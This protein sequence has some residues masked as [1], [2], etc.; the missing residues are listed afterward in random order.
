MAD[1]FILRDEKTRGPYSMDQIK[2]LA[3]DGKL[4]TTDKIKKDEGSWQLITQV[5]GLQINPSSA[6]EI[7]KK[8]PQIP[9]S[10]IQSGRAAI[11]AP[12]KGGGI[13]ILTITA[14]L[15][16]LAGAIGGLGYFVY[17]K[18]GLSGFVG[19]MGGTNPY[20]NFSQ[21]YADNR[22]S[23][24]NTLVA[25]DK[26]KAD[27][28]GKALDELEK[29]FK[30]NSKIKALPIDGSTHLKSFTALG[31][32]K[33]GK[34]VVGDDAEIFYTKLV[35]KSNEYFSN[36]DTPKVSTDSTSSTEVEV[37]S[38]EKIRFNT[39]PTGFFDFLSFSDNPLEDFQLFMNIATEDERKGELEHIICVPVGLEAKGTIPTDADEF[40]LEALDKDSKVIKQGRIRTKIP[41]ALGKTI[42]V[43]G[44][45][46]FSSLVD[47]DRISKFVVVKKPDEAF[48]AFNSN[49]QK[50]MDSGSIT[51]INSLV[52]TMKPAWSKHFIE[53]SEASLKNAKTTTRV[54]IALALSAFF[55]SNLDTEAFS[56]L[57]KLINDDDALVATAAIRVGHE[58]NPC[59]QAIIKKIM[60]VASNRKD[61]ARKQAITFIQQL[62]HKVPDNIALFLKEVENPDQGIRAI[63]AT[64]L[65]K[66][67]LDSKQNLELGT[68]FI[69]AD[70]EEIVNA[71]LTMIV[72][73]AESDRLKVMELLI[74][75]LST[76][77]DSSKDMAEKAFDS[78]APFGPLDLPRLGEGLNEKTPEPKIRI[79]QLLSGLK[80]DAKSVVPTILKL[81]KDESELVRVQAIACVG[82][83]KPDAKIVS[84]QLFESAREKIPAVKAEA[85]KT[86]C[87]VG[88]DQKTL[89]L[90]FDSMADA[91]S[92]VP[93]ACLM[94]F[95]SLNPLINKDDLSVIGP[96]LSSPL[97][98]V[99]RQA[100][101]ALESTGEAGAT[102]A[103][104]VGQGLDENDPETL[105]SALNCASKFPDKIDNGQ[106]KVELLLA[107][108]FLIATDERHA[109]ACL[110]YLTTFGSKAT[111]AIP[112]LRKLFQNG[113]HSQKTVSALK[114]VKAIGKDCNVLIPEMIRMITTAQLSGFVQNQQ[115]AKLFGD[116]ILKT[117]NNM[118][119]R[120][121]M[122]ATGEQ[123][124]K[125]LARNLLDPDPVVK[126]FSLL[127]L[128]SMGPDAKPAMAMIFRATV[129]A[130]EKN[131]NIYY[132]AQ[133]VYGRLQNTTGGK[134]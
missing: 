133:V 128:E 7:S 32:G 34:V 35:A 114:L 56:L 68:K 131:P 107:D 21:S 44:Y 97:V 86:L 96:R 22:K 87:L 69:K 93:K 59:P 112:T 76:R 33:L 85:I 57:E 53:S 40:A 2:K 18:G 20:G 101:V 29:L 72:K 102:Y 125:A 82:S 37:K 31:T 103:K 73:Q 27:L 77:F 19:G 1:F 49:L 111:S 64:F 122:A 10:K 90:L 9:G 117:N 132:L 92:L 63:S 74:P 14:S 45:L 36:H 110:N 60:L 26:I 116:E 118:V 81:F 23:E 130:N 124:A 66:A 47:V 113:K 16:L 115:Q 54:G 11:P 39:L 79:L 126:T 62:D 58:L 48:L 28:T 17:S 100:F 24:W 98:P 106:K 8:P 99:K 55:K 15:L 89:E 4:K 25:A 3:E 30:K 120:D 42:E 38:A 104:E 83:I 134:N 127:A 12:K 129:P 50:A 67:T 123:G 108:K 51:D 105:L 80:A 109:I 121:A 13:G 70:Q 71:G 46:V 91:D 75:S 5:K 88:R 6:S 119:L 95:S 43:K 78:L 84:A 61:D 65:A 52:R 41:L 94:G